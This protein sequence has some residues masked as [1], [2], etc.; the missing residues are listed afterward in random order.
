MQ[1]VYEQKSA[2]NKLYDKISITGR[3]NQCT[4]FK[5]RKINMQQVSRTKNS[6]QRIPWTKIS[7][8]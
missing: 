5:E 3:E 6:V 1:L 7:T 8:Q 2:R 4:S